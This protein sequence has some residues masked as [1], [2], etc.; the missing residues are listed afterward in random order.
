M[1]SVSKNP[2]TMSNTENYNNNKKID[3]ELKKKEIEEKYGA[4][5]SQSG[6]LPPAIEGQWLE[7]IEQFEQQYS[8]HETIS[9]WEYIGKPE[10]KKID[11]LAP[12]KISSELEKLSFIMNKN[13]I[14]LDT[15]REVDEKELYRFITEELFHHEIDNIHIEGMTTNFIY[16]EFY[17]NAEYDI[18]QAFDYLF[19]MTM[20]KMENIGGEGYD[21]LYI[22]TKSYVDSEGN[23]VDE[24]EVIKKINNFLDSFDYFE[25]ISNEIK[26][27]IINEEKSDAKL[28]F[29]IGYKGCFYQSFEYILFEG[30]GT[31]KLKPCEYGGWSI[32]NIDMPGLEI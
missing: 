1:Y 6:N 17:P 28:S 27:I 29:V 2:E 18:E 26:N 13:N 5:F 20:A 3:N 22:D 16:E 12:E 30:T 8:K 25:I 4:S 24:K 11:K 31:L 32:Y 10:F 14:M 21:L 15:L 23:K 7:S 19:R 9:V